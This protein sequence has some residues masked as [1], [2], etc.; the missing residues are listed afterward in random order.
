MNKK[1]TTAKELCDHFEVSRRTIYRDIETLCQAGIPIYTMKGKGG[2]I[3]LMDNFVLNKSVLSEQDQDDILTALS[4]FKAA[5][6]ADTD[7]VINKLG[8]L[9]GNK[10]SDWIEVDFSSW[11]NNEL[12]KDKFS[13]IKNAIIKHHILTFHYY[14]SY[15]QASSRS[16]EPYKL[17]FRGQ[18]WYLYGFC[19]SKHATRYF[20]VTRIRDLQ[21]ETEIFTQASVPLKITE[22]TTESFVHPKIA[23]ILKIDVE[24]GYRVYDEFPPESIER[25]EDGSFL[26]RTELQGG[27]WLTGYLMSYEHYLEII[28]PIDLRVEVLEKHKK[29]ILKYT[30]SNII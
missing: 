18:A 25:K 11:S 13:Q 14:N 27:G 28:E 19:R 30:N 2:G 8:A 10:N 5:T 22:E 20:K 15:G 3:S 9:F 6:N 23:M 17:V 7:Q 29:A 26:V 12:D 16:I 1:N 21:L 24:M 4:G